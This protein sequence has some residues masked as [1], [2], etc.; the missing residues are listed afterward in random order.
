MDD[1][2][3]WENEG[4]APARAQEQEARKEEELRIQVRGRWVR[5]GGGRWL[6]PG[7]WCFR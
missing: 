5:Q 3:R 1:E 6:I 2:Q 4:G 7:V